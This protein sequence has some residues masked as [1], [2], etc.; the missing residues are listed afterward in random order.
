MDPLALGA[1]LAVLVATVLGVMILSSA[2]TGTASN[3]ARHRLQNL[4]GGSVLENA[5]AGS[6][7]RE[8][9]SGELLGVGRSF[10]GQEWA[11][12]TTLDPDQADIHLRVGEYVAVRAGMALLFFAAVFALVPS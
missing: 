5:A 1:A 3:T 12:K 2:A 9:R 10:M 6:A 4:F 8:Q 7:L 11:A